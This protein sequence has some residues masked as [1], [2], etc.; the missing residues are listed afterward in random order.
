M[1]L[2]KM[3]QEAMEAIRLGQHARAR[4]LFT[5]LL[6]AD[7]SRVEFWLWMS[8]LVDTQTERVY[9]LE[10]ALK[11]DPENEAAR[12]GLIILGARTASPEIEPAP[13]IQRKWEKELD[14]RLKP[15]QPFIQRVKENPLLRL[16]LLAG[17]AVILIGLVAG[18]V[19]GVQ[20]P[21]EVEVAIFRVS[22]FATVTP[23]LTLTLT[24]TR[25][26][27]ISPTP[28]VLGATPLWMFLTQTYTP[29][30]LYIDTPH[31]RYESYRNGITAFQN[32][33]FTRMLEAMQRASA[34]SP[35]DADLIYYTG[36]AYRL[37]GQY[38]QA[39]DAFA[40]AIR[41]NPDFAPSYLSRALIMLAYRP[42]ANVELDLQRAIQADPNYVDAY[43]TRAAYWLYHGEPEE[44]LADLQTAEDI[45]PGKPLIYVLRAQAY[46]LLG[47]P[48]TALQQA[49]LGYEADRTLLPAYITLAR[50]YLANGDA[51]QALYYA[52]IYVRY[53]TD[54]ASGWAV[55]GAGNYL[56]GEAYYPAALEA[57]THAVELDEENH[58]ALRYR[59]LTYLELGDTRQAVT[60]LF[61]A[62][63][64]VS[65]QCD[66][67]IDLG[68][69]LWA[70]GRL[71][72]AGVTLTAAENRAESDTQLARIYYYRAQVYEQNNYLWDAK[73]DYEA[74]IALPE[75][76]VPFEW[77]LFAEQ[78][79][80]E[81]NPPTP[82]ATAT[83]TPL[84]T[85]TATPTITPTAT[86]SPTATASPTRTNT[87]TP[88]PTRTPFTENL[89]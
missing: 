6:R 41:V 34:A 85:P 58:E 45:F 23:T 2:E 86:M 48:T 77:R 4:D 25:T 16:G 73:M 76:A 69:A 62:A 13:L 5:R 53:E 20:R 88:T 38:E 9:C 61:N 68:R 64:L 17:A 47:D 44:A 14:K 82:T 54:D 52:E 74:L 26:P 15:P 71:R 18:A 39:L 89:P 70:D 12:R 21:K 83:R 27:R 87:R 3:Y 78:R 50:C 40:Q 65:Y 33:E 60:D 11:A 22:P 36:E 46:L 1:A 81:L 19:Y 31:P 72:E 49:L 42:D 63:Q 59:G 10:S 79:L 84:P 75:E 37:M 66:Y 30:P 35:D 67:A 57:F 28:T 43:L 8:T 29:E 24:P 32:G 51:E 56:R 80:A 7:P 55:I